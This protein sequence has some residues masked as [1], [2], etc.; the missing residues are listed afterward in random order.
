M[1]C[2]RGRS[3]VGF[4]A[5]SN[6]TQIIASWNHF[7][8]VLKTG[9]NW[10]QIMRSARACFNLTSWEHLQTQI[11]RKHFLSFRSSCC[12]CASCFSSHTHHP[13]NQIFGVDYA[14]QVIRMS[15]WL[16][17]LESIIRITIRFNNFYYSVTTLCLQ[18]LSDYVNLH[19]IST[20][21]IYS[22]L[23]CH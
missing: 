17:S 4:K 19:C 14:S 15:R 3:K 8:T 20:V 23:H 18:C 7:Q 5:C 22:A 9:S 6:H 16:E 2:L 13:A 11:D 10:H 21:W 1:W 12:L